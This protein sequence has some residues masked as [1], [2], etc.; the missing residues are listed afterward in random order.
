MGEVVVGS[1][2]DRKDSI[3]VY[4]L[5]AL[6]PATFL[7]AIQFRSE[8]T[9]FCFFAGGNLLGRM[10]EETLP[11]PE[12][13]WRRLLFANT[14]WHVWLRGESIGRV[15]VNYPVKKGSRLSIQLNDSVS[16]PIGLATTMTDW[17]TSLVIPADTPTTPH[18]DLELLHF[19]MGV[20]FRRYL[21]GDFAG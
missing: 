9:S 14:C 12:S 17:E 6:F 18:D 8:P 13:W 11:P 7:E 3:R 5:V 4:I 1:A 15:D 16:L 20:T 10:S 2:H 21:I 19:L